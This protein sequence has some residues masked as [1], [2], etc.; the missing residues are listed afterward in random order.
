MICVTIGRGRHASL[1][2][3][4]KQAAA[5]GVDLV[6]LRV[7]W[8]RRAPDLKRILAER[9]RPASSRCAGEQTA[10]SS[11]ATRRS[12]SNCSVRRS[13]RGSITSISRWTSPPRS[14][15]SAR[16]SGSSAITTCGRPPTTSIRSPSN[17][18]RGT[19]MWSRSPRWPPRCPTPRAFCNSAPRPR[20]QPS[21]SR[22]DRLVSSPASSARSSSPRS[23]MRA[24]TPSAPSRRD[25]QLS[26]VH[27]RLLL[28]PD[29]R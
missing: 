27:A 7:D 5:A 9:P 17:V 14:A 12:A 19:P 21:R 16:P 13:S 3:E 26:S 28:Q 23:P 10:A 20:S 29:Q 11:E 1:A 6:E 18:T 4:W 8:L 25:A 24:S 22:W 2:E 15:G